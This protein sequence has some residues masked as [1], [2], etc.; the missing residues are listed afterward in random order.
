MCWRREV[1]ITCAMMYNLTKKNRNLAKEDDSVEYEVFNTSEKHKDNFYRDDI[2]EI[3][4]EKQ[5][6]RKRFHE[7]SKINYVDILQ[8]FF[9]LF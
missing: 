5:I 7:F 9:F 8:K 6:D 1:D 4:K 2:E 3:I